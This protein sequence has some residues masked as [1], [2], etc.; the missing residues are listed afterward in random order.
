MSEKILSIFID[1][2]G[3]F[4][5][6]EYHA[7]YYLV[8]MILHDQHVNIADNIH[9]LV[10]HLQNL[11]Y[12]EHAIHTGPL[13]RRESIYVNDLMENRKRLFNALFNFTRKL[14]FH[15]MCVP[16][17]KS[18]CPDV[19][20]MTAKL[21]KAIA[22]ALRQ[23]FDYL[24]SFDRI[25]IYYDNGQVELTK[26]LT[27]VFNTLFS[28]VEFRKVRPVDY[29]LFQVADLICTIELLALKA[30]SN[31]FSQSEKEFFSSARDFKKNYRKSLLKKSLDS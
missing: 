15:Y 20:A 10:A 29:K 21:S 26:I 2:S 13:I 23:H 16:I 8:A 28:C 11:G 3:D 12:P 4:G 14:D 17:K 19:I 24:N 22:R 9:G 5:P 18:E 25:I 31:S 1:E 27:S 30:E 6:Y 7:P